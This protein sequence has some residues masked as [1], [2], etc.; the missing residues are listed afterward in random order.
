MVAISLLFV[1]GLFDHYFI[2][3]TLGMS[4]EIVTG[5][6]SGE[7]EDSVGLGWKYQGLIGCPTA[8]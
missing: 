6:L 8:A 4:P 2:M 7:I 3:Q 1:W 5:I